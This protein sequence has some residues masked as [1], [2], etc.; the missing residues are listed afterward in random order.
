MR[1]Q[2]LSVRTKVLV[3]GLGALLVV[4]GTATL[5]SFRYWEREQFA[6]TA[7]HALM[8]ARAIRPS[9]EGALAHGQVGLV[10]ERLDSLTTRPPAEGYRI[11]AFDGRV[12]LSSS[13][14]EEGARRPGPALPDPRDIPPEGLV[15]S[16]H[17][18][19]IVSAVVALSGVGGPGGRATLE[20]LLN[21][22][23]IGDTIR[24]GRTYGVALTV[25]LGLGYAVV[26]GAMLEREI[27]APLGQLR[28]GLARARAGEQGARVGLE[29]RDEFGRLGESV[30]ALIAREQQAERL[31]QT[32]GRTLVEQAGFAEVGALAAEVG[33]EIKRPLAGI[34][35]AIELIAQEYAMSDGEKALLRRVDL[36]LVQLD[37][38][39]RDLLSLAK[40]V[41]L[42]AQPTKLHEVIDA[43]LV[44]LSGVPGSERVTVV[45][46]YGPAV[47]VIDGDAARLE[48]AMH[49]VLVN[50]V[51]AMPG[52]GTLTVTT[53]AGGEDV[54]VDVADTGVGIA[55][56]NI[57]RILKPFFST[58][59]YGTGLGLAL[60]ARVVASHG[61]RVWVESEVGR[62]TVFHLRF[63]VR[64]AAAAAEMAEA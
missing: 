57:D 32:R 51:E 16:G 61:G 52:G 54:A 40:P 31:A 23:R 49:N 20:F 56:E 33:H 12:L 60:V 24:R 6:L 26:L 47:P 48:Q 42:N 19:P 1:L 44:R 34:K 7:D 58:K 59:P 41:G 25:L 9:I 13:P 10:R 29:R 2:D 15:V 38:T 50:A 5:L 36:E 3:T 4:L 64:A 22:K 21:E 46:D 53:R 45:R 55:P 39:L 27:V 37:Q 11:V 35:S 28:A 43:A 18:A 14:A 62:G 63:P 8:A 30:D 17:G